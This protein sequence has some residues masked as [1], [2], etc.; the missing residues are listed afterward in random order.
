MEETNMQLMR[1]EPFRDSDEFFRYLTWPRSGRWPS[2]FGQDGGNALEWSPAVDISETDKEY[3]VKAE[4][5]GLRREDVRVRLEDNLLTVEGERKH[6]DEQKDERSHRI[7]RSYGSFCRRFTL[8]ED[9]DAEHIRA[10]SKDG[11]LTVHVPKREM[12]RRKPL[13]IA[14]Q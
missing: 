7:E 6:E 4:L 2:I 9:A 8:P 13:E 14:V 11:I 10:E 1:W 12:Q 5:P 3:L